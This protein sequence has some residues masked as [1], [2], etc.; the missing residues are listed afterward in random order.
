MMAVVTA[1]R[2][3]VMTFYGLV[4]FYFFQGHFARGWCRFARQPP[5]RRLIGFASR[6]HRHG[7]EE[8]EDQRHVFH[9]CLVS[10]ADLMISSGVRFNRSRTTGTEPTVRLTTIRF[11]SFFGKTPSRMQPQRNRTLTRRER[12]T[13]DIAL[14]LSGATTPPS[15]ATQSP[16]RRSQ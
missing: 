8:R 1:V 16:R 15:T 14:T 7:G 6:R 9:F 12:R 13:S 3:H 5:T 4:T 10:V 2:F 11:M